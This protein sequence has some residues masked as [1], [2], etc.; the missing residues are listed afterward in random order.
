MG[1]AGGWRHG[2]LGRRRHCHAAAA[3]MST[4]NAFLLPLGAGQNGT[5]LRGAPPWPTPPAP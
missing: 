2:R 1:K 3:W 5:R 4:P